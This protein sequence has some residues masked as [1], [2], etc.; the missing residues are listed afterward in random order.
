MSDKQTIDLSN[1]VAAGGCVSLLDTLPVGVVAVNER[2]RII[3]WNKA[4]ATLTGVPT[5]EALGQR[6]RSLLRHVGGGPSPLDLALRTEED[7]ADSA[8]VLQDRT[9]AEVT[10]AF[11]AHPQ[12]DEQGELLGVVAALSPDAQGDARAQLVAAGQE[13]E[14]GR[15]A[16]QYLNALPTPILVLDRSLSLSFVNAAAGRLIGQAPD[17]LLGQHCYDILRTSHCQTARCGCRRAMDS[18]AVVREENEVQVAGGALP[19]DY[20]AVPL[21]DEAGQV[22]GALEWIIDISERKAVLSDIARVTAAM[23]AGDLTVRAEGD[24]TGD[25]GT[26]TDNLNSLLATQQAMLGEI[27]R[28]TSAVAAGDLTARAEGSYD[29]DYAAIVAN[30]NHSAASQHDTTTQLAETVEQVAAAAEQIASGSQ[31]VAEGASA[32]AA[33]LQQASAGLTELA[34]STDGNAS[35]TQ[36]AAELAESA[37]R[38]AEQGAIAVDRMS[39]AMGEIRA[40][41]EGTAQIIR[42]INEISFQTNLLALNAAV[43]A[44]R[45]GDAGR[46]FA[47]VAEEVRSLAQRSKEAA[48]KT[49]ELIRQSVQLSQAGQALSGE[50]ESSLSEIVDSVARVSVNLGSIADSSREQSAGISLLNDAMGEVDHVTQQAAA[51]AEQSASAAEELAGQSQELASLVG[52]YTLQR[53]A[54]GGP[55]APATNRGQLPDRGGAAGRFEGGAG[56]VRLRPDDIIP[57]DSDPDFQDF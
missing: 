20:L 11:R 39:H 12:L 37:R 9:G 46:G 4:L 44:A 10:V 48:A 43:E 41:A 24:Y 27:V 42:D 15:R 21:R 14:Q 8:F 30:L 32:Q 25:F 23:A 3:Y 16:L 31:H 1:P 47:V 34:R 57:L 19:I 2:G 22:V 6:P 26:I 17:A 36:E 28:V 56:G 7:E 13:L 51:S 53:R 40:A 29:G 5:D 18:G 55:L 49:E 33:A 35:S 54:R 45:A 38:G 50:A 52:R